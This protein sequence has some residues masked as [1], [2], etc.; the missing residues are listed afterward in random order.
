MEKQNTKPAYQNKWFIGL[1]AIS[2]LVFISSIF[3]SGSETSTPSS[4]PPAPMK[5]FSSMGCLRVSATL[6]DGIST[7]LLES[8][9]TGLAAGFVSSEFNDVK[10]VALEFIPNGTTSKEIAVFATND[11]NLNDD[12]VDGLIFP[13]DGFAKNFSD[14]GENPNLNLSAVTSG[15]SEAKDCLSLLK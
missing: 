3:G 12:S 15:V 1:L 14:W 13:A 6:V 9:P 10:M 7:G 2:A 5:S 8:V 11:N 4:T